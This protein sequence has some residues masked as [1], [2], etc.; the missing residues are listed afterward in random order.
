MGYVGS[1]LGVP[2]QHQFVKGYEWHSSIPDAHFV[3][4][5]PSLY[6][7]EPGE[8]LAWHPLFV[9]GS[10]ENRSNVDRKAIVAV[11]TNASHAGF[12]AKDSFLLAEM[13]RIASVP[14][15]RIVT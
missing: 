10:E 3:G 7:M 8:A 4:Q 6:E 12:Q 14:V 11:F 2:I 13:E 1:H 5:K 9:H 15:D